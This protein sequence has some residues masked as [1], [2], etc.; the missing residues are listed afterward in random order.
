MSRSCRHTPICQN[1]SCQES[2][3]RD[4]QRANGRH[5]VRVRNALAAMS[6]GLQSAVLPHYLE[7]ADRRLFSK[8]GKQYLHTDRS[9][10]TMGK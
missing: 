3:K 1:S 9:F 6:D 5:R 10:K 8:R 4:K 2:D 7:T